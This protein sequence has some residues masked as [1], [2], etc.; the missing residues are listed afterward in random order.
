MKNDLVAGV[1]EHH[2]DHNTQSTHQ[3]HWLQDANRRHKRRVPQVG[4]NRQE[5]HQDDNEVNPENHHLARGQGCHN[6]GGTSTILET[7][8]LG[9]GARDMR[10]K[11]LKHL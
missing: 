10:N 2:K 5:N 4:E 11:R 9:S 6:L 7:L 3:G 1:E 8:A